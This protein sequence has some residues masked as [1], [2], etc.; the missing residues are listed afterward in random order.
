[1]P[2]FPNVAERLLRLPG[3]KRF[4]YIVRH[5]VDRIESHLAHNTAAGAYPAGV[6][7]R[8]IEHA[9]AVSSYARQLDA[10]KQAFPDED[11]LILSFDKFRKNP[12]DVLS[13]ICRHLE[14]QSE[15]E[16][17]VLEPQN[18]RNNSVKTFRLAPALRDRLHQRLTADM[19][20][21]HDDYGFDVTPWGFN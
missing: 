14:V 13:T 9:L 21:L 8:E 16:W 6:S 17:P 12:Y 7:E 5:P 10:Y 1:M 19:R 15:I 4:I 2:N 20:R 18:I 3:K 11:V